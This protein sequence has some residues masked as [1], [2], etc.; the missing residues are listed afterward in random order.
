MDPVLSGDGRRIVGGILVG[1]AA[2]YGSLLQRH[3]AMVPS[4]V[5]SCSG[6]VAG[7]PLGVTAVTTV[8][9]MVHHWLTPR[10]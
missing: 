1:D 9:P 4:R 6:A 3:R 7:P 5:P 8:G 10:M 2:A